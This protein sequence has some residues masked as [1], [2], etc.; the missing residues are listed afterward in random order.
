MGQRDRRPDRYR[1]ARSGSRSR[2]FVGNV[3]NISGSQFPMFIKI[4][5]LG[6]IPVIMVKLTIN[7]NNIPTGKA[8]DM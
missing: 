7:L 8:Q 6:K 4:I 3:V 5:L 1:G 2:R